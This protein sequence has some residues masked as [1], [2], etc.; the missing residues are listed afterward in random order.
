MQHPH[1]RHAHTPTHSHT[2]VGTERRT[3]NDDP[4][5]HV[6]ANW[7]SQHSDLLI[8]VA[9]IVEDDLVQPGPATGPPGPSSKALSIT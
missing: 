9:F 3:V 6:I 4:K 1:T 2:Y 5:A 7:N 8:V